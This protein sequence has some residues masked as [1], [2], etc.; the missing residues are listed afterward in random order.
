MNLRASAAAALLLAVLSCAQGVWGED[1]IKHVVLVMLENRAFD[2]MLGIQPLTGNPKVRGLTGK[3]SNPLVPKD[4][5]SVRI[6]IS[7]DAPAY[8]GVDP[9]HSLEETTR[10]IWG[11]NSYEDPATMDGFVWANHGWREVMQAYNRTTLPTINF[12]SENFGTMDAYFAS[13]PCVT[14]VNRMFLHT[15]QSNAK[16]VGPTVEEWIDEDYCPQR[17]VFQDLYDAGHEFGIFYSDF[18]VLLECSQL[19]DYPLHVHTIFDF[20]D[21]A[22]TGDLPAYS[23]IEPRWFDFLDYVESDQHPPHSTTPGEFLLADIYDALR[24]SPAWNDT[25]FIVTY[26]EHGG[27]FD[28]VPPPEKGVKNPTG[29]DSVK[30]P[31]DFERLGVRVPMVLVSP[32]IDAKSVFHES[33]TGAHYDHTSV[34][35]TL[36]KL[37]K[38][39]QPPLSQREAAAATFEHTWR[40]R[41]S[42]RSDAPKVAP[43][44][45][46]K[47]QGDISQKQWAKQSHLRD[48]ADVIATMMKRHP[49][50]AKLSPQANGLQRDTV[51]AAW[52]LFQ[53]KNEDGSPSFDFDSLKDMTVHEGASYVRKQVQRWKNAQHK[54]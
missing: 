37:F 1:P 7:F 18:P 54:K 2:S 20:F 52:R 13:C 29:K 28:H 35:A 39:P 5:H 15:T 50:A 31:F 34:A 3:E 23:F 36:R 6:P 38:L 43:R 17:T 8:I 4:P 41:S 45:D 51:S 47:E 48:T 46:S 14:Q 42:P 12:L 19:R 9:G 10:E 40:N 30:P 24:A 33:P 21:R 27:I 11:Q 22:K 26:D 25:L 44:P 53:D 16:V 32:W 49:N